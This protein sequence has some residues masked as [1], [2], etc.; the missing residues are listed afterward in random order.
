MPKS[1]T[2]SLLFTMFLLA[3]PSDLASVSMLSPV[4]C[5]TNRSFDMSSAEPPV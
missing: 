4:C 3:R 5:A 2:V 1:A